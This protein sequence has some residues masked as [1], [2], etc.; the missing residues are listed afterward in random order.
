[1]YL[2]IRLWALLLRYEDVSGRQSEVQSDHFI[3]CT[4]GQPAYAASL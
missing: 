4:H 2:H 1:M 3:Q